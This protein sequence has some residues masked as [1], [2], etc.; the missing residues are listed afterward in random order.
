M[1]VEVARHEDTGAALVSGTL[2]PQ[3]VDF[4]V[5]VHLETEQFNLLQKK[6][7]GSWGGVTSHAYL[8]VLEHGEFDL[9]PL[10]LVLL[11]RGVGLLLPLLGASSQPQHE[12]KSRLLKPR[13]VDVTHL[14]NKD[15]AAAEQH[16]VYSLRI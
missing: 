1:A 5:L 16:V 12:V 7:R 13:R 4:T 3:T 2:T 14:K 10:V 6:L 11:G 15:S 9:L 8:V